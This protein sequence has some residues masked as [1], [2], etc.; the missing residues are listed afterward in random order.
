M[1]A[2]T[3]A[4]S[5][6]RRSR[7]AGAASITAGPA[8]SGSPVRPAQRRSTPRR[9]GVRVAIYAR[10]MGVMHFDEKDEVN[11]L[12]ECVRKHRSDFHN[13][14]IGLLKP[15]APTFMPPTVRAY[16]DSLNKLSLERCSQQREDE[17]PFEVTDRFAFE[18]RNAVLWMRFK[19]QSSYARAPTPDWSWRR[20]R[21]R[22]PPPKSRTCSLPLVVS[23]GRE[24]LG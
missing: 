15:I 22:R 9:E 2:S 18:L 13:R 20:S 23:R 6:S 12:T 21:S 4:S 19:T 14:F 10:R 24:W 11:L 5:P 3:P 17:A 1:S 7:T 8:V 16:L